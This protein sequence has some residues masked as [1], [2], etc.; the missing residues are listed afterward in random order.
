VDPDVLAA[1]A[2]NVDGFSNQKGQQALP[3]MPNFC[4][5]TGKAGGSPIGI[6]KKGR[7]LFPLSASGISDICTS[8][9]GTVRSL[10]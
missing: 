8:G 5:L 3:K 1:V 4:C 6:V 2:V 7:A 10:V 9:W